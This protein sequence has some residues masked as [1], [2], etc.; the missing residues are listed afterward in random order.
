MLRVTA[1][2]VFILGVMVT[3]AAWPTSG[4][5]VMAQS[6]E[7]C[8]W[9][10]IWLP[11][12]GE[13]S[14]VQSGSRVSGSYLDGQGFVSGTVDG[15]T[16]TGEW[17]EPPSHSPPF[18]AGRLEFTISEDCNGIVGTLGLGSADC[19]IVFSA[20]RFEDAPPALAVQVERGAVVVEGQTIQAGDTYFPGACPPGERSPE[21]CASFLF[22]GLADKDTRL[23]VHCFI[24]GF[25]RALSVVEIVETGGELEQ[26]L[27]LEL[28]AIALQEK[29]GIT[30]PSRQ[31]DGELSLAVREGSALITNAVENQ[32][33]RVTVGPATSVLA[34]P[35]SFITGYD[36]TAAQ[37]LF[38]TQ[39]TP[40][41]VQPSGAPAF[42]LPPFSQVQVTDS[43]PRS[44]TALD[45]TY[46]PMQNR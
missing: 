23:K 18:D 20:I 1:F 43:G 12:E 39:S 34:Q 32:T 10:G 45:R 7:S 29:C 21:F 2:I 41:D 9:S 31:G 27:L 5:A 22:L 33:L 6:A 30:P 3:A 46:L 24:N 4:R 8:D 40:L 15:A 13:W 11:F 17:K 37:A 26:D 35:G 28:I 16:L 19:C 25:L 14:F 44:I 42:T 38:R 36:P